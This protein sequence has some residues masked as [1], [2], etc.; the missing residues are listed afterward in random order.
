M[1][2]LIRQGEDIQVVVLAGSEDIR[3]V[4]LARGVR[5]IQGCE[6]IQGVV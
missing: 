4:V 6:D 5:S 1:A 3:R 2:V